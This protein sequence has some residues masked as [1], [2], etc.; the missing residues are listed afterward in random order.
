M[1][2]HHPLHIFWWTPS[3]S[4]SLAE[5][6]KRTLLDASISVY[7]RHIGSDLD[8]Y[9]CRLPSHHSKP[10]EIDRH[11]WHT[12]KHPQRNNNSYKIITITK[13]ADN[14][15]RIDGDIFFIEGIASL[16]IF[17]T[18]VKLFRV[19]ALA[20][21]TATAISKALNQHI[22]NYRPHGFQAVEVYLDSES[23]LIALNETFQLKSVKFTYAPPGQNE[24][25]IERKIRFVNEICKAIISK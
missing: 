10:Q 11:L 3:S 18:P 22:A 4:T 15:V 17:G 5:T 20:N 25:V 8:W 2:L 24:P 7:Q 14:D 9:T 23:R 13:P 21:R 19:T 16:L 12:R 1:R 6:S